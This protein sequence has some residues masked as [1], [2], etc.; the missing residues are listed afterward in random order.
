MKSI[1]KASPSKTCYT[2]VEDGNIRAVIVDEA[3]EWSVTFSGDIADMTLTHHMSIIEVME[4]V[5]ETVYS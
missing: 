4:L 5:T 3:I 1:W 2:L